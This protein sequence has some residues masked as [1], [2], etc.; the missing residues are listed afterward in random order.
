MMDLQKGASTFKRPISDLRYIGRTHFHINHHR[1]IVPI[2]GYFPHLHAGIP[3]YPFLLPH[4]FYWLKQLR[5]GCTRNPTSHSCHL[6]TIHPLLYD[7]SAPRSHILRRMN[8][9]PDRPCLNVCLEEMH[10]SMQL[11]PFPT[12]TNSPF[13][14]HPRSHRFLGYSGN[15]HLCPRPRESERAHI[16]RLSR[17]ILIILY[18]SFPHMPEH[19]HFLIDI[20]SNWDK[21]G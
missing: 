5:H 18:I 13:F 14:F 12:H 19:F 10:P 3:R 9:I 20:P 17:R 11:Q 15:V 8:F 2:P 16:G 6:G 21:L 7:C 1:S 4:F